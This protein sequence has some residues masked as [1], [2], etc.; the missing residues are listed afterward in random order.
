MNHYFEVMGRGGDFAEFYTADV[1]WTTTDTGQDVRG[2]S[3]VR[4][5]IVTLHNNM[6]DAQT[7]R[8]IVS[9][10]H[11]YLEGDCLEAPG[12]SSRISY[13]VAY[14][15]VDDQIAAMRCYGSDRSYVSVAWSAF[16]QVLTSSADD[17]LALGLGRP[18]DDVDH[19]RDPVL[20]LPT[21]RD[22]RRT[23]PGRWLV[24]LDGW[25]SGCSLPGVAPA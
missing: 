10:G 3:P 15:I 21:F 5:F 1:T 25:S 8:I 20:A 13:C 2:A 23:G 12:T 7:R 11:A 6:S 4:D 17:E 18:L 19:V 16:G 14:D 24:E 22:G 9:D